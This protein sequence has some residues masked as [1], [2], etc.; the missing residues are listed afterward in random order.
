MGDNH[1]SGKVAIFFSGFSVFVSGREETNKGAKRE[2]FFFLPLSIEFCTDLQSQSRI[3]MIYV[4]KKYHH[5]CRRPTPFELPYENKDMDSPIRKGENYDLPR[6]RSEW[7]T[8]SLTSP[9]PTPHGHIKLREPERSGTEK[10]HFPA[11]SSA[12][13]S[14][15]RTKFE[16]I[17]G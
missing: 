11:P 17:S 10:S 6:V 4:R 3:A 8:Q 7:Y 12:E 16:Q 13:S 5:H 15:P 1:N 2:N 14:D 9:V